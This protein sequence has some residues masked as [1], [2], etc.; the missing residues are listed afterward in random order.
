MEC[1]LITNKAKRQC[2]IE[3]QLIII[4]VN[5]MSC[6]PYSALAVAGEVFVFGCVNLFLRYNIM[7]LVIIA[8]TG[9]EKR[10]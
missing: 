6:K 10:S 8:I 9:K 2:Q 3:F 4:V 1:R 5:D 7:T